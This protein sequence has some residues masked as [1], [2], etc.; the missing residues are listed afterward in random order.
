MH[1]EVPPH[2]VELLAAGA[3]DLARLRDVA[4]F[5]ARYW[6][7]ERRRRFDR[8]RW[9]DN[10]DGLPERFP[11]YEAL[12]PVPDGSVWITTYG[13]RAPDQELHLLDADGVW[14]RCLTMPAGATGL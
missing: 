5:L 10:R 12:L 2:F 9:P 11:A 14:I 3:H 1:L 6:D 8:E 13:W 7:P 4:E